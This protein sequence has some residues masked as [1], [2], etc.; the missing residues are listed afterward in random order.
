MSKQSRTSDSSPIRVDFLPVRSV[1]LP[2]RIGMTFAPG[3]KGRGATS[4]WDR[5][6]PTDLHR[7][8]R[9]YSTVI[10]VTL[11]ESS[12]RELL[13]IP[14]LIEEAASAGLEIIEFPFPDGGVPVSHEGLA[15][16]VATI[17][18]ASVEHRNVTIHCRGGLGRSGLV[19][20]ACLL[21]QGSDVAS[22]LRIVRASRI[23][24]VETASQER[25]LA[26]H[27]AWL[28]ECG[29]AR[30]D[31][32]PE[33]TGAVDASR[34]TG[35]LLGG[36]LGD[37]LGYPV[38]FERSWRII[39]EKYRASR[40]IS[41]AYA[42]AAPALISDDTQ[43]TLFTAEG[44]VRTMQRFRDRGVANTAGMILHALVRWYVTQTGDEDT[45]VSL[46]GWLFGE[47]RL[48]A[49]RAPGNTNL[50]ALRAYAHGSELPTLEMPPN[51]SKGC[52]AIMRSAPIGLAAGSR[53][54]AFEVARDA[55]VVTHGHSSGYLSAA[56]FA[57]LIYDVARDTSLAEAM[58]NADALLA[59]HPGASETIRAI[60]GARAIA[61]RGIPDPEALE[62]LGG[63][64][65]AEEALAIAL[66]CALTADASSPRGFADALWR[67][68][69]HGGDSDSTGS[70]V[71]NL[72]GAMHGESVLPVAWLADLELRDVIERIA[73]DLHAAAIWDT[74]LD[75][76]SYPPN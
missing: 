9:T 38:E 27:E 60:A 56:Y 74:E 44:L 62:S 59:E 13:R 10:L 29:A 37:A 19:A 42:H 20:A 45:N 72:L 35:C 68:V 48:H 52:G 15:I 11:I 3:K 2:G 55:A 17:L 26:A 28:R 12:E 41:L 67:S 31:L 58:T 73:V 64:W 65:V 76:D 6:L 50:S 75:Y 63:G 66:A 69:V 51:D 32:P 49:T 54:T 30:V 22:A 39:I 57:A 33:L 61:A 21:A 36:A 40:P 34:F 5:D 53:E 14:T 46:S 16:L 71:G 25:F 1:G 4:T 18:A 24:A 7:L 47:Q 23:G 43:M 70:L 8:H